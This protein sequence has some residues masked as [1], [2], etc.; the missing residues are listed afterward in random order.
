MGEV[1]NNCYFGLDKYGGT[2]RLQFLSGNYTHG[3]PSYKP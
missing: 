3:A 2:R 1:K